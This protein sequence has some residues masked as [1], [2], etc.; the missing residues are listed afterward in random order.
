MY[1]DSEILFPHKA[2]KGL[3]Y[4]RGS[5][6]QRLMEHILQLPEDHP[7]VIAFSLL[8]IR[9]AECL[10]CDMG[11]Y[12]AF[13]GCQTCSQRII[14]GFKGTDD[15]LLQLYEEAREDVRRYLETGQP[16]PPER[17]QPVKVRPVDAVEV[18]MVR[19]RPQ[20]VASST[21]SSSDWDV[22]DEFIARLEE[23][24]EAEEVPYLSEESTLDEHTRSLE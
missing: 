18:E 12:K 3:R 1:P 20:T 2:I 16:P 11:S 5:K 22:L 14:A 4:L 21:S 24:E 13:L 15:D 6:W 7:D 10:H 19:S 9:L 17:L 8:M 23:A